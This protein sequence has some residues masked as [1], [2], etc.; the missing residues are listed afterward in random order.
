MTVGYLRGGGIIE[1]GEFVGSG[2]IETVTSSGIT[3][4]GDVTLPPLAFA[5]SATDSTSEVTANGDITLPSLLF[6]GREGDLAPA[7]FTIIIDVSIKT[8]QTTPNKF[9]I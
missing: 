4:N 5:G 2:I 3:A 9:T 1:T 8:I 6:A 7:D